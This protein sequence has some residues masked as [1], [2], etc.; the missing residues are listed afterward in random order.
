MRYAVIHLQSTVLRYTASDHH[1][2]RQSIDKV[3][4]FETRRTLTLKEQMFFW[5]DRRLGP[6]SAPLGS[7]PRWNSIR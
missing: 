7:Y 4:I 2:G 1:D 6:Y 3:V 5:H